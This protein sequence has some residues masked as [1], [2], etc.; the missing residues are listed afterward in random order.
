MAAVVAGIWYLV[1]ANAVVASSYTMSDAEDA[2]DQRL[3]DVEALRAAIAATASSETLE[4]RARELG[5]TPVRSPLY[6]AVP[7][8]TVARR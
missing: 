8:T 2:R 1:A 6:L 4:T 5:F 7:G 3:Q